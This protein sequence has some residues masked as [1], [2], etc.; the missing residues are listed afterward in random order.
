MKNTVIEGPPGS[1][2]TEVAKILGELYYHLGL[3]KKKHL[4]RL[5][6]QI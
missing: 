6:L 4:L 1:G 2:K 3:V 5:K